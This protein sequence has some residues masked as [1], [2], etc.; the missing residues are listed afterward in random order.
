M[1]IV[2]LLSKIHLPINNEE[3]EILDMFTEDK[4]VFKKDLNERQQILAN[5]LV[6]KD[7]LY[8]LKENG[9]VKYRKKIK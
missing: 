8:R 2:E 9:R 6:N 1:R 3:A 7:V 4:E 5:Q